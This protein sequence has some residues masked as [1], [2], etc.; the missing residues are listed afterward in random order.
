MEYTPK[1]SLQSFKSDLDYGAQ[2]SN[3]QQYYLETM[4]KY[5][6]GHNYLAPF[7][8]WSMESHQKQLIYENSELQLFATFW[9]SGQSSG[10][11]HNSSFCCLKIIEGSCLEKRFSDTNKSGS[12]Q[13]SILRTGETI[14]IKQGVVHQLTNPFGSALVTLHLCQQRMEG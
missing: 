9:L 2:A 4:A 8:K 6:I 3:K 14:G 13:Y 7:Y 11:Q 10:I 1:T 5:S 12:E